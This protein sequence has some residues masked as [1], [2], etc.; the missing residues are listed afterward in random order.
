[1]ERIQ[2]NNFDSEKHGLYLLQRDAPT[3]TEKSV[4]ENIPFAQ[5]L[6]DYSLIMGER[7]FNNREIEYEFRA[8]NERYPNRKIL[9]HKIKQETMMVGTTKLFDSH[10]LGFYWLGKCKSVT[11]DDDEGFKWL[12]VRLVFDVYPF[13]FAE[14][15]FLEDLWDPLQFDHHAI[16]FNN[17]RVD[18]EE[19][20]TLYNWGD[21]KV[22]PI[23]EV[24]VD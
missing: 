10:D 9:E 5:G 8:F 17:Y 18:G 7:I 3:P 20:I 24:E 14:N 15:D 22:Y 19:I 4:V 23:V 6:Q 16:A 12:T 11:V 2:F 21:R 1:M 13:M